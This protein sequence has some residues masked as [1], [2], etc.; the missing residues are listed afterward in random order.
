MHEIRTRIDVDAPLRVVWK[1][2]TD[3]RSYPEWNPH[4]VEARGD[5]VEGSKVELRIE[6]A[7]K[8]ARVR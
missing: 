5:H 1:T 2:L 7:G 6:R 3:F 8:R 4:V